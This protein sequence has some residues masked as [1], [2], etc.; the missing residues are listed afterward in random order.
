M[1]LKAT[2][3]SPAGRLSRKA[4]GTPVTRAARPAA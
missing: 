1:A 4:A 3:R 2:G